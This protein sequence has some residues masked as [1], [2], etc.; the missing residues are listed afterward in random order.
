MPMASVTLRPGV[1]TQLTLA[2]NEA[3]VSQSQLIRYDGGLIQTYGG[4]DSF[5]GVTVTSTVRTLHPFKGFL[6]AE[7]LGIGAT[8]SLSVYNSDDNSVADITPQIFVSNPTPNFSISSGS[9]VVTVVDPGSSASVYNTVFFNTPVAVGNLLLNGAYHI[10]TVGGSS[11]YTIHSSVAAST[12]ITSS[13]ILPGF[14][15]SAGSAVINVTLPNNN[16]LEISGL[17]YDFIA[18]TTVGGLTIQ[19]PYE[20]ASIADSTSFTI[21]ATELASATSSGTMN[22]S[23]AQLQYYVTLGPQPAGSGFGDLGFGDGG[24]GT[25]AATTGGTGTPI[26]ADDWTLDNW[27]GVLIAVPTDGAIYTWS[28]NSGLTNAQVITE[29][30]F[31]NGGAFVSMPQQIIVAWRSCQSTGVQGP[32]I[33][34]WSDAGD[35]TNWTVSNQTAAGSFTIPTGSQIVG[36]L[37]SAQQGILWT[38]IDV[39][40]QQYIG[41]DLTFSHNRVGS[42]CGLIGPH[43]AGTLSGT[44]FWCGLNSFYTLSDRGVQVLPC[45]VWDFIFQ[46]LSAANVRKI[47][48]ATNSLFNE[49][50]WYFPSSAGN[51]ENDSY[52][53]YDIIENQWDYGTLVRTAWCDASIIGNPVG[54]DTGAFLYSHETGTLTAGVSL[55]S[56]RS[57]WWAISEG[58]ELAFVD[59]VMPDFIWGTYAG[60]KDATVNLTFF[61]VD[62]PGDAVRQYGP[63][64]VTQSTQYITPR[65]RGRLMSVLVQSNS[66][67]FWRL[68]KVRY[69]W[70]PIGRR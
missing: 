34:R 29:A 26:T 27:G 56:F 36:G 67:S 4:W 21:N 16:F 7:Y 69:R 1:N 15:V 59:F 17:F 58:N 48:C 66:Q 33:V 45:P 24:F 14:N 31:F 53:K 2:S 55:P 49:V 42:G 37:Q 6:D 60:A 70:A 68:G 9:V 35:Y 30:P 65:I 28:E 25:G 39:W 61:S 11:I 64:A 32:L 50:S 38:D 54:A 40:V 18:T 47:R 19:G 52:V 51:G 3:G 13:G 57:G 23:L 5:N 46:N 41:G 22:S 43:A 20:I 12:T 63:Y 10:Q 8:Q 62:Y 44:V